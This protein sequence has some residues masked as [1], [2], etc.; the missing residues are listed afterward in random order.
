MKKSVL[1]MVM[2]TG[3]F[4]NSC[5]EEVIIPDLAGSL[6]GYVRTFDEFENITDD[7]GD[8]L[9]SVN[10]MGGFY[11]TKTDITGR[12]EFTSLSAGT[13]EL[14]FEK[15]GYGTLKHSNIKHLGGKP[16]IIGLDFNGSTWESFSLFHI[17]TTV[18]QNLTIENDTLYGNF[19]FVSYKPQNLSLMMY[20]ADMPEYSD[21]EA[22]KIIV[23]YLVNSKGRYS[24]PMS[25]TGLPFQPGEIVY[26]RAAVFASINFGWS[27]NNIS[28]IDTDTY[29]H[30]EFNQIFYPVFGEPS[31]T[32]SYVFPG[33]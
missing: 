1:V 14:I 29:F 4:L 10:G 13:Y 21:M 15:T 8:V 32:Y 33:H 25:S 11:S 31:E 19:A 18:I 7:Q 30:N 24:V 20:L 28:L 16:T 27:N 3:I 6:V 5:R 2:I 12:F 22:R 9:V 26:F 17:P 23:R